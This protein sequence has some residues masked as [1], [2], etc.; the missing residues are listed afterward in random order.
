MRQGNIHAIG[1][2]SFSII[3]NDTNH[4]P[5][6]LGIIVQQAKLFQRNNLWGELQKIL[7]RSAITAFSANT[8]HVVIC[9][10][11]IK[12][13]FFTFIFRTQEYCKMRI[14]Q[15]KALKGRLTRAGDT[16]GPGIAL[17]WKAILVGLAP[18]GLMPMGAASEAAFSQGT[19]STLATCFFRSLW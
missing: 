5:N 11:D 14:H 8:K 1:I 7:L 4:Q 18:H 2:F 13:W 3:K 15:G 16:I 10:N 12:I 6:Y 19:L 17:M 9:S